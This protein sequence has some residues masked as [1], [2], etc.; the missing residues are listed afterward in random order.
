MEADILN[1]LARHHQD[2]HHHRITIIIIIIITNV[3]INITTTT[4]HHRIYVSY[5]KLNRYG[6]QHAKRASITVT[7]VLK[8]AIISKDESHQ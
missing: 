4:P 5:Q 2:R 8:M 6:K 3:N 1:I 7:V